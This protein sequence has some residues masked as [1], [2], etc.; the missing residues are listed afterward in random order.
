MTGAASSMIS[1]ARGPDGSLHL[2]AVDVD[3]LMSLVERAERL[4]GTASAM[5]PIVLSLAR[6][7]TISER[8]P[9]TAPV[10]DE[11]FARLIPVGMSMASEMSWWLVEQTRPAGWRDRRDASRNR[12]R[13]AS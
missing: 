13:V 7:Y 12:R 6:L 2:S 5:R 4:A 3:A 1:T 9:I 8:A 11:A 10:M